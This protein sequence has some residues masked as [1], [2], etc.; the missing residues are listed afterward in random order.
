[1][2]QLLRVHVQN[3]NMPGAAEA[4]RRGVAAATSGLGCVART[5]GPHG[6]VATLALPLLLRFSSSRYCRAVKRVKLV[7]CACLHAACV[8]ACALVVC[9]GPFPGVL[10]AHACEPAGAEGIWVLLPGGAH[11]PLAAEGHDGGGAAP[12]ACAACVVQGR[13][14]VLPEAARAGIQ[15]AQP[16]LKA[17][18][19]T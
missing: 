13:G 6:T 11:L 7:S 9:R 1:M 2:G 16:S 3:S 4:A 15:A 10:H 14:R 12:P 5:C 17:G 8:R 18:T 19:N